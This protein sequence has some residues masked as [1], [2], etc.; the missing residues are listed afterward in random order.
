VK[1]YKITSPDLAVPTVF[2]ADGDDVIRLASGGFETVAVRFTFPKRNTRVL[3]PVLL[4]AWD[5]KWQFEKA[6]RDPAGTLAALVKLAKECYPLQQ[7]VFDPVD[8]D[9]KPTRV[10]ELKQGRYE[11]C[12]WVLIA[13]WDLWNACGLQWKERQN[14]MK[15]LGCSAFAK[16]PG[17]TFTSLCRRDMKLK[18][19]PRHK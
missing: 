7:V 5:G 8:A 17:K 10:F 4:K 18:Y 13:H 3:K 12:K 1:L 19:L 16:M 6:P 14:K 15:E 9:G 11:H 2:L